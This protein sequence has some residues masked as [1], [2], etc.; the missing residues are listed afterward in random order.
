[1][2]SCVTCPQVILVAYLCFYADCRQT[3]KLS[4]K[5]CIKCPKVQLLK[6]KR[7]QLAR[8]CSRY[9]DVTSLTQHIA[10]Y[11]TNATIAFINKHP[12]DVELQIGFIPI[13]TMQHKV[14][15]V[16]LYCCWHLH[17]SMQMI[18]NLSIRQ[19]HE[20]HMCKSL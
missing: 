5:P 18:F 20:Q 9:A 10:G 15:S 13:C 14:F 8:S 19:M 12:D 16:S 6:S 7:L 11:V 17:Q 4:Y 3:C 1:M 2:L